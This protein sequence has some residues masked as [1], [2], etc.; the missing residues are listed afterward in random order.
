M[1]LNG[2]TQ[3]YAQL[4]AAKLNIR[5]GV[6]GSAVAATMAADKFLANYDW[7]GIALPLRLALLIKGW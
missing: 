1:V 6:S 4:L 7:P 2:I 3:L 5:N